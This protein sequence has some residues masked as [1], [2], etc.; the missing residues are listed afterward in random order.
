VKK[1]ALIIAVIL[2]L[3][4][5]LWFIAIPEDLIVDIIENS[6]SRDYLYLKT[7]KVKK[8]L[9]YNFSAGRV[10]L[11]KKGTEGSSD[12]PLLVF[13]DVTG[14]FDFLSLFTLSP[15]LIFNGRM[16]QGEVRGL[17]RLTGR[18]TLMIKG[19]N[20]SMGGIPLFEPLGIYGDGILS[21]S[22]LVH[23]NAGELKFSVSDARL[24]RTSLGGIFLPLD[25][26]HEI[27]GAATLGNDIAEIQSF[28]MSGAGI[29]A[30]VRGAIGGTDM[31]L[32]LE[33]MTD[34]SFSAEPLFQFALEKYRVSPGYYVIPLKGV[35]PRTKGG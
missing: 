16:N 20:I 18:D 19:G 21:G 5:G 9:F 23:N 12:Y 7:E 30:R 4:T 11:M 32:S 29:Y 27:K 35:I 31:N 8:G 17:V 24:N 6:L 14:R 1:A 25:L 34:S 28:A 15:E 10:L 2:F 26:F 3:V 33:L 22:F 13:D